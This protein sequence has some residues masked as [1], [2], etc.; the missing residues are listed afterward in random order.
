M[1]RR[2]HRIFWRPGLE[3]PGRAIGDSGARVLQTHKIVFPPKR[4]VIKIQNNKPVFPD[5][6]GR[7]NWSLV[8]NRE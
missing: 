1:K 6:V 2:P 7:L 4:L 8:S 5:D 3:I